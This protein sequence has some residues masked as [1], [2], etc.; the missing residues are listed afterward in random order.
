MPIPDKAIEA[1]KRDS[2][3]KDDEKKK[4][5]DKEKKDVTVG[6]KKV[7]SINSKKILERQEQVT[8]SPIG[9]TF[10]IWDF[11]WKKYS[12]SL[13]QDGAEKAEDKSSEG[14]GRS[15]DAST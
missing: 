11:Y 5:E 2:A 7:R 15:K 4:K 12:H 13:L 14:E 6:D 9:A 8:F 1:K 10:R 3:K